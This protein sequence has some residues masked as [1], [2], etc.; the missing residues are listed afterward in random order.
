METIQQW[1]DNGGNYEEGVQLY[2][3]SKNCNK[4][5]LRLFRL[6]F[7]QPNQKKLEYELSKQLELKPVLKKVVSVPKVVTIQ[8]VDETVL[9]DEKKEEK[10]RRIWLNELPEEL[11]PVYLEATGLFRE[12]CV[13]KFKLNN[14]PEEAEATALE[15]IKKIQSNFDRNKLLWQKIQYF[16]DHRKLPNAEPSQYEGMT[17]GKLVQRQ[18]LLYASISKLK[19]RL[20]ENRK[21][22]KETSLLSERD[23]YDRSIKKQEANLIQKNEEL[24][25]ITRLIEG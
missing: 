5:L 19:S 10:A 16:L 23:K 12:N 17:P 3:N 11:H 8:P 18:Q 6:K 2:A 9:F 15:L 25:A 22:Y 13:L 21:L 7:T 1:V 24:Q 4:N 14:L 20:T